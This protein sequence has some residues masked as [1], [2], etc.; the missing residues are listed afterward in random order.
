MNVKTARGIANCDG[1]CRSG[2]P[3]A[4]QHVYEFFYFVLRLSR[5]K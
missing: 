5:D 2:S 1:H 4:W 3:R